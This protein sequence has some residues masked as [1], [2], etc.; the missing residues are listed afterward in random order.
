[1]TIE[2][3]RQ[4]SSVE[5]RNA[6]GTSR[7]ATRRPKRRRGMWFPRDLAIVAAVGLVLFAVTSQM[8]WFMATH[9]IDSRIL[10]EIP[11]GASVRQIASI[12]E[13][14]GLVRDAGKFVAATR[15]LRLT[16]R[17]QAG[18][19]EFGPR[20]SELKVL[21]ALKY[22]EVAGRHLTIP[23]GYRASQIAALLEGVLSI[24]PAEFMEL[25][26][27]PEF[28]TSLGLS[29]PSLEG[30]LHPDTYRMRLDTTARG[31]IETM[32]AETQRILDDRLTARAE[33]LGMSVHEVVTLASIIEA[34]AMFDSERR[35]ISAVYHNRLRNGWRLEADPTVRYALGNYHRRLLY[36]DLKVSSPYNTYRNSGLPPGPICSPGRR[37]VEAAVFPLT[38][39]REFF[40]VARGDGT[41]QFSRTFDEHLRAKDT[42]HRKR[43]SQ[44]FSLDSGESG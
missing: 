15:V 20:F 4:E 33:S 38:N 27:D 16:D 41:H 28:I 42:I 13:E 30:Y 31:A 43:Q 2:V 17:L 19:Y 9:E 14:A 37:S 39:T 24:D 40:F 12:L 35:R 34:E 26:H 3:K 8:M 32:V 36:E 5:Q 21:M 10:V 44:D 22:G 11:Q 6:V 23:E 7:A 18:S 29:A 1:M 25:V